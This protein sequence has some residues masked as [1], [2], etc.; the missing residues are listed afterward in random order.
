MPERVLWNRLK[1]GRVGG[2]K[3]RRQHVLGAYVA[4]FYCHSLRL[5]VE[6][7][8]LHHARKQKEDA[9][10]DAWMAAHALHVLRI[11][12]WRLSVDEDAV[13]ARISGEADRLA[14]GSAAEEAKDR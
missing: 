13:I 10:R 3:F 6:I 7:D 2:L 4:D 5:V 1:G 9:A 12:V 14:G 8:G 11:P